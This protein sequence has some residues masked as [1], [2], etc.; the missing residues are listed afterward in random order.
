RFEE[1]IKPSMMRKSDH[2]SPEEFGRAV[3]EHQLEADAGFLRLLNESNLH[4]W[5]PGESIPTSGR[6]IL[7]GVAVSNLYDMRLMDALVE[8]KANGRMA[9]DRID[10][11]QFDKECQ[12]QEQLD[13]FIPGLDIQ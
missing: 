12:T 11:F 5:A 8:A 1:L 7:I 4:R 13:R 2:R 3:I 10:V 9:G 6:R